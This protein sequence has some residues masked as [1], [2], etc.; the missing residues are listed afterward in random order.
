MLTIQLKDV[1]PQQ[2]PAASGLSNFARITAGGFAA[3]LTTAFWDRRASLHQ[4]ALAD[5]Q[6]SHNAAFSQALATLHTL[7]AGPKQA[8]ASLVGQVVNQ[9]YDIAAVDMFWLFGVLALV[10]TPLIWL[11]RR[12]LA[13]AGAPVAAD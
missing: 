12:S 1:T 11:A 8:L 3:S 2:T 4:S 5:A 13:G 10:M 7:G 9:A 6:A